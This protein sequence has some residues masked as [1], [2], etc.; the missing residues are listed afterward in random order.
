MCPL[1]T[2]EFVT[3][4]ETGAAKME[5]NGSKQTRAISPQIP[6]PEP[7]QNAKVTVAHDGL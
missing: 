4:E 6:K 1:P 5:K 3:V 7:P 2:A